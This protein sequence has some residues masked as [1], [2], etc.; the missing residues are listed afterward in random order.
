MIT[1][2]CFVEQ[3][4]LQVQGYVIQSFVKFRSS[5]G[6]VIRLLK[7]KNP[8]KRG[9]NNLTGKLANSDW[10]GRFGLNDKFWNV[11]N[12][13]AADFDKLD[14]NEFFM[15][16]EDFRESF[17]QYTV[18]YL[19]SEWKKSFIEKRNA[20]N[21]KSYRFNFTITDEHVSSAVKST[22][23]IAVKTVAKA[24]KKTQPQPVSPTAA[25]APPKITKN[26]A[27]LDAT[28]VAA[29]AP[30]VAKKVDEKKAD[31]PVPA[32]TPSPAP[33]ADAPAKAALEMEQED[34]SPADTEDL[35]LSA[36]I[37]AFAQEDEADEED[38]G[39]EDD[40]I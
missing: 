39:D 24:E 38:E 30:A 22:S 27:T 20:L 23:A 19:H 31:V 6:K 2:A 1:S 35:M 14:E 10:S 17:K 21:K 9:D 7:I 13:A 16:V 3:H 32:A 40:E 33:A 12:K 4:N 36:N 37:K 29:P 11:A 18:T 8:F 25:P 26:D 5:G 34:A 28:A 15:S